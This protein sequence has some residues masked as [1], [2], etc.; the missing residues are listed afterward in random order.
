MFSNC[1]WPSVVD[2]VPHAMP[3]R[4]ESVRFT[5]FTSCRR[6][7]PPTNDARG[8]ARVERSA[9]HQTAAPRHRDSLVLLH[10]HTHCSTRDAVHPWNWVSSTIQSIKRC[11]DGI[12]LSAFISPCLY[13]F[14]TNTSPRSVL[15]LPHF[16]P[17][18]VLPLLSCLLV[19]L[20]S[21][22][23]TF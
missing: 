1:R 19:S 3:H 16:F 9:Q 13:H 5:H 7:P 20:L 17:S 6:P 11:Y 10:C 15:H 18:W 14:S 8:A 2:F 22:S 21:S 23:P 4:I 12:L